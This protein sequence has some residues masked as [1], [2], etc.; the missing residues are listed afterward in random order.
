MEKR[1]KKSAALGI[2]RMNGLGCL[3]RRGL[4]R[5]FFLRELRLLRL[6]LFRQRFH[7]LLGR[8]EYFRGAILQQ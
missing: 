5:S 8:S 2:G 6:L 1:G 3:V 7:D 4:L